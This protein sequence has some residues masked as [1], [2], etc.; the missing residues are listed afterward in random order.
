[1]LLS[2]TKEN[3]LDNSDFN[4]R[5]YGNFN[6]ILMSLKVVFSYQ[7]S[8]PIEDA[9]IYHDIEISSCRSKPTHSDHSESTQSRTILLMV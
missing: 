1:M 3:V 4:V 6:D 7:N 9:Y 8:I 2:S 5:L